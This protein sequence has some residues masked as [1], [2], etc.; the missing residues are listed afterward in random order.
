V[1]NYPVLLRITG[2][3]PDN[4]GR[5]IFELWITVHFDPSLYGSGSPITHR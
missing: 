1:D 5:T 2:S 4:N 3:Y